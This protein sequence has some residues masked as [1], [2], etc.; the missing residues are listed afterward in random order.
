[1]FQISKITLMISLLSFSSQAS[2]QS[3]FSWFSGGS[4]KKTNSSALQTGAAAEGTGLQFAV[5]ASSTSSSIGTKK[6]FSFFSGSSAGK[7]SKKLQS[8]TAHEANNGASTS[9]SIT[10]KQKYSGMKEFSQRNGLKYVG[11]GF[12]QNQKTKK[13]CFEFNNEPRGEGCGT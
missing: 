9:P 6:K 12:Y 3:F 2:A 1:M 13:Y 7:T 10:K 8:S 5:P 11:G 4:S